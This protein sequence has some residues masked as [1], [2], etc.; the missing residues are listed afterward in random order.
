MKQEIEHKLRAENPQLVVG[1]DE[2]KVKDAI[3]TITD[4]IGK[5]GKT[6]V[7]VKVILKETFLSVRELNMLAH[8]LKSHS[9]TIA[10][11]HVEDL[12]HHHS[13]ATNKQTL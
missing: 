8:K 3:G 11:L 1:L 12:W 2:Q 7:L 13:S 5:V 4:R 10:S 9:L 6:V